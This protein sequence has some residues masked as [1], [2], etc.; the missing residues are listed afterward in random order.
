MSEESLYKYLRPVRL[1]D[2]TS[3]Q[4]KHWKK[5]F[6][7]FL[8]KTNNTNDDD[9]LLLLINFVHPDI[10][11]HV[12]DATTFAKAIE[13]LDNLYIMPINVI[14]NRHVLKTSK[15]KDGENLE[16]FFQRLKTLSKD[17]EFRAVT[18]EQYQ[19]EAIRDAFIAGL[20]STEIRRRLLEETTLTLSQAFEK[21]HV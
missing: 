9:K 10:Y 8:A 13:I 3:K 6:E 17:C 15:Q 1:E 20:S 16:D 5:T 18:A 21:A 11:D 7:N 2:P 12:S 4:Y 14:F 19:S